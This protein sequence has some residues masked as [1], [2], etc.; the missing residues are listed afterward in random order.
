MPPVSVGFLCRHQHVA[1]CIALWSDASGL[2]AYTSRIQASCECRQARQRCVLLYFPYEEII[3]RRGGGHYLMFGYS[4]DGPR[5]ARRQAMGVADIMAAGYDVDYLS[6]PSCRFRLAVTP[7]GRLL[8]RGGNSYRAVIVPEVVTCP[9]RQ[10]CV[11]DRW[12]PTVSK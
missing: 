2:F 9:P 4:Q 12:P 3:T 7:D 11:S 1:H 8:S 5:D 6:G 10:R